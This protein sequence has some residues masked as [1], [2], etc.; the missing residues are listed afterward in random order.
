ML[1]YTDFEC[2]KYDII[3]IVGLTIVLYS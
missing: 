1:Y 2:S 3:E